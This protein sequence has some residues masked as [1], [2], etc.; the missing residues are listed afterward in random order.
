[1]RCRI[2]LNDETVRGIRFHADGIC[3][4]CKNYLRDREKLRDYESLGKLFSERIERIRGKHRYD[5]AVGISGGKDSI[6][7]LYELKKRYRLRIKA[8]TLCN[9]FLSERARSNIDRIVSELSVEHEYIRF[10][11]SFLQR[12]YRS[13]VRKWLTPCIACSYLGYAS[14]IRFSV[15]EDAALV[16]HGRSPEQ[17]F[18]CY[19]EDVFT[20]LIRAGLKPS[21]E[22]ELPKLY[23]R[24]LSLIEEKLDRELREEARALLFPD[25]RGELREFLAYFLYH[26]YREEEIVRFLRTKTSWDPGEEYQHYDC[27]I[28]LAPKYIYQRAEGR[29]HCLPELSFLVRDSQL[30]REEA[31]K[32]LREE[33]MEEKPEEAMRELF[34]FIGRPQF[35]TLWKAEL[36]RRFLSRR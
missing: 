11:K 4:F 30:G 25:S 20:E 10:E 7:V 8:F 23:Q 2:C 12:L 21:E 1:M 5:A 19:G 27:R 28:H 15:R 29:P 32:R 6:Y 9:G 17:M 33:W 34:H 18:R 31:G 13:S 35:P 14:M 26:P 24:L 16:I 3:N 36:Y 22:L